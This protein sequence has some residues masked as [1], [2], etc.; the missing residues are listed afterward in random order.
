M[1]LIA[2]QWIFEPAARQVQ[3]INYSFKKNS[4]R[5]E[6]TDSSFYSQAVPTAWAAVENGRLSLFVISWKSR[7]FQVGHYFGKNRY[8]RGSVGRGLERIKAVQQAMNN[9]RDKDPL[10]S[11]WLNIHRIFVTVTVSVIASFLTNAVLKFCLELIWL[12]LQKQI[13]A[14][15]RTSA[16]LK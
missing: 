5:F 8:F 10:V 15:T 14:L 2:Q 13:S 6:I 4:A 3:L 16:C 12:F 11:S 1:Q 9:L 7:Y